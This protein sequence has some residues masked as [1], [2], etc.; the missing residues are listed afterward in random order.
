MFKGKNGLIFVYKCLRLETLKSFLQSKCT[1]RLHEK[2]WQVNHEICLSH[3]ETAYVLLEATSRSDNPSS[4]LQVF[5]RGHIITNS[6]LVAKR[7]RCSPVELV[8]GVSSKCTA[9]IPVTGTRPVSTW[10]PSTMSSSWLPHQPGA[11]ISPH[12]D[13]T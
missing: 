11:M 6:R 7:M 8:P 1:M 5:R 4:L 13:G 2:I 12:P 3:R 10:T 9:E